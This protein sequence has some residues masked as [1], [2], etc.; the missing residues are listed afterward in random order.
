MKKIIFCLPLIAIMNLCLGQAVLEHSYENPGQISSEDEFYTFN[1][2]NGINYFTYNFINQTFTIYNESHIVTNNFTVPSLSG[3]IIVRAIVTD[4]LF[5]SDNNF[6]FLLTTMND[7][8]ILVNDSGV[9]LQEFN[10]RDF[11]KIIKNNSGNYKLIVKGYGAPILDVYSLPGTLSINQQ[12]LLVNKWIAFP[13]PTSDKIF[14]TNP[15]ANG[16]KGEL[17]IFDMSG[18]KVI[19]LQLNNNN[20]ISIDVSSLNPGTYLYKINNYSSK[21]IKY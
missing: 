11:V 15:L 16:E 2:E 19:Q 18:K 1:A 7:K 8:I 9:T 10:N 5:N 3:D 21:F 6:E 12:D 4:K 13:N 14:I 17:E 20:E